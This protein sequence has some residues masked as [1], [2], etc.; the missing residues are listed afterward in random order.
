MLGEGHSAEVVLETE[1]LEFGLAER[2]CVLGHVPVDGRPDAPSSRF[3]KDR[4]ERERGGG[5]LFSENGCAGPDAD[6]LAV[7]ERKP[8]A[9]HRPGRTVVLDRL[10]L[11]IKPAPDNLPNPSRGLGV[12][13]AGD[14]SDHPANVVRLYTVV[15][16][17]GT[18]SASPTSLRR[19][20]SETCSS[21]ATGRSSC[22][23]VDLVATGGRTRRSPRS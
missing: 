5:F 21:W 10:G 14:E 3:G 8:I 13:L 17:M 12:G 16:T 18:T 11:D 2:A 1:G 22:S 19:S 15:K 9:E 4:V 6:R 23:V 7:E 20:R